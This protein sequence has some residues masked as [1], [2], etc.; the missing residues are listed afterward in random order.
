MAL[1]LLQQM[2]VQ[3]KK[4]GK[5]IQVPLKVITKILTVTKIQQQTKQIKLIM[6]DAAKKKMIK[7]ISF[8]IQE[9]LLISN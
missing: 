7:K 9:F 8:I 5:Y 1:F 6:K 4:K 2:Q 3:M